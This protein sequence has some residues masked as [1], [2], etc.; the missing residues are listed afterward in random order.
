MVA[1]TGCGGS[2]GLSNGYPGPAP[3]VG[4]PTGPGVNGGNNM[5]PLTGGRTFVYAV[6]G[7]ISKEYLST[8][9]AIQT[10]SG[11]VQNATLTRV[12]T[13]NGTSGGANSYTFTDTL[14]Y[15]LQGYAPAVEVSSWTVNQNSDNSLSLAGINK[16][17]YNTTLA[18]PDAFVPSIFSTS[19][20]IGGQTQLNYGPPGSITVP[21]P[22]GSTS[23]PVTY[24]FSQGS[25]TVQTAMT[26]LGQES[27]P[28]T[29]GAP[30]TAWK[31]QTTES[32]IWNNSALYLLEILQQVLP[33]DWIAQENYAKTSIDD[34]VPSLGAPVRSL[35]TTTQSDTVVLTYS[36][37]APTYS[38]GPTI[39][40][41]FP[42]NPLVKKETLTAVL[43]SSH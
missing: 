17:G 42:P 12:I 40:F 31:T 35:I 6:S 32:E 24:E 4:N 36:A 2:N 10:V 38:T 33:P 22:A 9:N 21:P 34:W 5:A 3:Q 13:S 7:T 23:Q 16:F 19:Q 18:N 8:S 30:Y 39:T 26:A 1:L 43:V 11:Q 20:N 28:T 29:T 27:V 41:T 15:T 14:T 25:G 37:T